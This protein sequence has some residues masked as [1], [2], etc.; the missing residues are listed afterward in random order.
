MVNRDQSVG[1][2]PADRGQTSPRIV[3][4]LSTPP[5]SNLA[6]APPFIQLHP[7]FHFLTLVLHAA[8][9]KSRVAHA[10]KRSL[11]FLRILKGTNWIMEFMAA[12]GRCRLH[13]VYQDTRS[14]YARWMTQGYTLLQA[15]ICI[16]DLQERNIIWRQRLG[17]RDNII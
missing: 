8:A 5:S 13:G 1:L 11:H 9:G 3:F 2:S 4:Q 16:S 15:V 14:V 10:R 12:S 17:W 7:L 6:H